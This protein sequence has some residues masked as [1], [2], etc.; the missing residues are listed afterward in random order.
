MVPHHYR[1]EHLFQL[2]LLLD[3]HLRH[4]EAEERHELD[5]VVLKRGTGEQ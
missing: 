2:V 5:E 3:E 1:C 4:D